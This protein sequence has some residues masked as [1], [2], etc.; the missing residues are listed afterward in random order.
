MVQEED[1]SEYGKHEKIEECVTKTTSHLQDF[2]FFSCIVVTQFST[3][4]F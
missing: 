2:V 3:L 4:E 1:E